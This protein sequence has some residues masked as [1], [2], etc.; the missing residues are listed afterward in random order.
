MPDERL[1]VPDGPLGGAVE[2]IVEW[3][4]KMSRHLYISLPRLCDHR[5][6]PS[7]TPGACRVL[8][9]SRAR[10]NLCSNMLTGTMPSTFSVLTSLIYMCVRLHAT[11]ALA[12][13]PM[14]RT[15]RPARASS[16]RPRGRS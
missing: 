5:T 13:T 14:M 9:R 15:L 4:E 2:P 10:R 3:S 11:A 12:S 6:R 7:S 1:L 16:Y 8:P